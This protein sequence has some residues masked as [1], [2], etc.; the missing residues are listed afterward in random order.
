MNKFL[1]S[2]FFLFC[3][4]GNSQ[5]VSIIPQPASIKT[6]KGNFILTKMTVIAVKDE[7]DKKTAAFFNDYLQ[8]LYGFTLPVEKEKNSNYIRL[9]TKKFIKAPPPDAYQMTV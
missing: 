9:I 6:S 5:T 1:F 7:A 8:H 4:Y 2:L 3:I